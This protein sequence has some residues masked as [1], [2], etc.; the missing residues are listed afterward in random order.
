MTKQWQDELTAFTRAFSGAA[1]FGIPLAFTAEMWWIGKTLSFTHLMTLFVLG[2][3]MNLGLAHIAGFRAESSFLMALDQAIDAMAVGLV[4]AIALLFC[5]NQIG[6]SDGISSILDTVILL[7]IVFSLGASVAREVFSSRTNRQGIAEPDEDLSTRQE[8]LADIAATA[9]GGVFVG[10]SIA[11]TDEVTMVAS[12]LTGWHVY[13]IIGLTLFASYLIVFASGF[14][15]SSPDGPFQH[16]ITETM[17]AYVISLAVS[18]AML[19]AMNVLTVDD[20]ITQAFRQTVVL[21]LPV[22]IGGAAG[23]LVV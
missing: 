5:M 11:P 6:T 22:S 7:A 2:F 1:I 18:F 3:I 19:M 23:R 14:D 21:A 12:G 13:L 15:G 17:L 16:P 8:L 10:L 4:S 9:I 20:S